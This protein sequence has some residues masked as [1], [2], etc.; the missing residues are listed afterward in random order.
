MSTGPRTVRSTPVTGS[1]ATA[2]GVPARRRGVP[3]LVRLSLTVAATLAI[4]AL[5][6]SFATGGTPTAD[7]HGGHVVAAGTA[8]ALPH[9][10][11]TSS[12]AA[13]RPASRHEA[14]KHAVKHAAHTTTP[15][16]TPAPAHRPATPAPSSAVD[17]A[18]AHCVALTFD[19]GP[20]PYTAT[21]L[22]ELRDLHV[23]ATFFLIG[24]NV[25]HYADEVR[26][27]AADGHVIGNHTWSH[28]E[29][30]RLSAHDVARE[31]DR[32]SDVIESVTGTV[33][34]LVRP[35]YGAVDDDVDRVLA[36]RGQAAVLWDVDTEDWKNRDV[37]ETTRRA[38]AGARSGSIVLMHD[39]HPTTVQAVPGIVRALRDE[40]YT[41]VTVP[42]LLGAPAKP[43]SE[44]FDRR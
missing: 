38:L 22:G 19:D 12:A 35:P 2:P 29:L 3:R 42:E 1:R 36:A 16:P 7:G 8:P 14:A 30:T 25:A 26:A 18:T 32:T 43:G 34:T 4:G 21:L 39:I 27:E 9:V 5:G 15:A 17:C 40:G 10:A 28:P 11:A 13:A 37:D 33:P 41:L 20:G 23:P 44:V 6:V 31:V 24:G